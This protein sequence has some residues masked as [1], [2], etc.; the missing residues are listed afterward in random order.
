VNNILGDIEKGVITRSHVTNYCE[1][2]TFV[3]SSEP[4]KV[5]D[6]LHDPDWVVACHTPFRESLTE[7]S[8]RVPRM[9]NSHVQ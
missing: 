5:E 2:Y 7:A 6:A 3:S 9:F 1:H 8:I 4:F